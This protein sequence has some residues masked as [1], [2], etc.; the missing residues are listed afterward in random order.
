MEDLLLTLEVT[1]AYDV[2]MLGTDGSDEGADIVSRLES[3]RDSKITRLT[4]VTTAFC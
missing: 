1:D 2:E 4:Q 3:V